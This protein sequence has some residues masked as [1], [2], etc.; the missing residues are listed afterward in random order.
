MTERQRATI[1]LLLFFIVVP[2]MGFYLIIQ[3]IAS[4]YLPLFIAGIF[5]FAISIWVGLRRARYDGETLQSIKLEEAPPHI[6]RLLSE[7]T[8]RGI[9]IN[10]LIILALAEKQGISQT[11]LYEQLP[12]PSEV[13]PT[14][15][16]VRQYAIILEEQKIIVDKAPEYGEAKKKIYMLTRRGQW[17]LKAIKKYYP[18]Y[19]FSFLIHNILKTRFRKNLPP[20]DSIVEEEPIHDPNSH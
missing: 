2:L 19:Y 15:E 3:A 14:K 9:L 17:C 11:D 8:N 7:T 1:L 18:R 20:Y 6:G 5:Y 16:R 4:N 12:I 10:Q 13:C